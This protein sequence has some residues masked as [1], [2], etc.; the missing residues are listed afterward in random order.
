VFN[1]TYW[2]S[3]AMPRSYGNIGLYTASMRAYNW[4]L[5]KYTHHSIEPRSQEINTFENMNAYK[6]FKTDTEESQF[7][8][9]ITNR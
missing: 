9:G 5:S 4:T 2:Y 8:P 7:I 1:K 3:V 6:Y